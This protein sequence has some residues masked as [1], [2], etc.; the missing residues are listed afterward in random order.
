MSATNFW[1]IS[2]M[3]ATCKAYGNDYLLRIYF[4]S[5]ILE[6]FQNTCTVQNQPNLFVLVIELQQHVLNL[7][8]RQ[9][10]KEKNKNMVI[11]HQSRPSMP[12]HAHHPSPNCLRSNL[13]FKDQ[14]WT[15]ISSNSSAMFPWLWLCYS[16]IPCLKE[17]LNCNNSIPHCSK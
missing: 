5:L 10:K 15:S 13:S 6:G 4:F 3:C 17:G 7:M 14:P 1:Q 11:T 12:H 16:V 8:G 2:K 9:V